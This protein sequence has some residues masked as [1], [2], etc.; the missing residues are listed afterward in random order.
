MLGGKARDRIAGFWRAV[1]RTPPTEPDH[2]AVLLGLFGSLVEEEGDGAEEEGDGAEEAGRAPNEALARHARDALLREHLIP[3]LFPYLLKVEE[4]GGAFHR[5]WAR[6]LS[7]A[8]EEEAEGL[9]PTADLPAHLAAVPAEP[10]D[11]LTDQVLTP[12]RSG[13]ILTRADL[14]RASRERGLPLRIG[15]RRY[16]LR[17]MLQA[18][19]AM[20]VDWLADEA[21][22][23]VERHR[24]WAAVGGSAASFWTERARATREALSTLDPH[25]QEA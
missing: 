17:N 18:A 19:P 23:W 10:L 13:L 25:P 24:R 2:L 16:A 22:G 3:W 8:L 20:A 21:E 14:A 5:G 15:E 7:Q 6:L 4:V 1:G 9:D 11:S 12:V